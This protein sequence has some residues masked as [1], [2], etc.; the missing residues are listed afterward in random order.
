ME[1][2]IRGR[3]DWCWQSTS[4]IGW[5]WRELAMQS[6]PAQHEPMPNDLNYSAEIFDYV[7]ASLLPA[8]LAWAKS[9]VFGTKQR[10][11]PLTTSS[12]ACIIPLLVPHATNSNPSFD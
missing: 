5:L 9:L 6:D 2:M 8:V 3:V 7:F 1:P 12:R 4:R 11:G 10:L